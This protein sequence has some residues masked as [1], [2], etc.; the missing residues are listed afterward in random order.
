MQFQPFQQSHSSKLRLSAIL[1]RVEHCSYKRQFI[2]STTN[3]QQSKAIIFPTIQ[4]EGPFA[5]TPAIFIRLGGCNL[6]CAPGN[7]CVSGACINTG[8]CFPTQS[9]CSGQC[10]DTLFDD[11]HC[12]ACNN[13]CPG[14]TFCE[15][16]QCVVECTVFEI[17][18][19]GTCMSDSDC[20]IG[21]M[22]DSTG[23]CVAPP[24]NRSRSDSWRCRS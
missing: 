6:A 1:S 24:P 5:G 4:G 21:W 10:V 11:N 16:G 8:G 2:F 17:S 18:C 3:P 9:L 20:P 15:S 14:G 13:V 19:N 23:D 7:I 22:C 12:G